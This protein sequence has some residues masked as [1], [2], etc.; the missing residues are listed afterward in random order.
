MRVPDY[1][2]SPL[3]Y[4]ALLALILVLSWRRLPRLFRVAGATVEIALLLSIAPIGANLLVWSVESRAPS[5]Q[6][7]SAPM[8]GTVVVLSGGTERRPRSADDY[9]ALSATSL[10]RL[11]AGIALWRSIPDARLVIAGGG[12]GVP[13]SVLLAG[14]AKRMGVPPTMIETEKRSHTTWENALYT[15]DLS[16]PVPKRIWLVSSA[17]HLPRALGAFRAWGFEPCAWPAGT[18]HTPFS[19]R[20]GYFVP[21]S[22]SLDKA[23]AAI[24]ELIGGIVYRGLEW[25]HE[26]A[27]RRR[28]AGGHGSPRMQT[29]P[30]SSSGSR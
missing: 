11:F 14:L 8:P 4:A 28:R 1:A 7:C 10:R 6:S 16:P 3:T 22:S 24:H 5:P 9:T 18:L 15:A 25:K 12:R 21:Q 30:S 19:P 27:M 20:L 23:D 17:L 13:E 26:R 29:I 2:L